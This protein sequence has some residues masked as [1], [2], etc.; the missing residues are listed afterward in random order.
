MRVSGWEGEALLQSTLAQQRDSERARAD[1]EHALAVLCGQ[2]APSFTVTANPL[3]EVSP[4]EVPAGLPALLLF[5]RPDVAA[6]EQR[7]VAANAQV[8]VATASLYP[9]FSITST[10]GFESAN[11]LNL[12]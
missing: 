3:L 5:R 1:L 9:T 11:L 10:A 12:F 8:G 6:A 2:G 4:P 7:V